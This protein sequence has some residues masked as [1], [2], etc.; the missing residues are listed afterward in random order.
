MV[1]FS[2]R[3]SPRAS[4]RIF[5]VKLPLATAVV[6]SAMERTCPVR[7]A[8]I[9][10][11]D[12]VRSF[13]VPDTPLTSA[14]PPSKP[15]VPTSRATRVTSSAKDDSWSTIV[16]RVDLSSRISPR[17]STSI[18]WLRSPRATAVAT[19][20]MFRT[21]PVR[22]PAIAFTD[23][24]RSFQV[25]DTPG[26]CAWPPSLPSVPTSRATRVTSEVNRSSWS[27]IPLK[28]VAISSIRG[29]PVLARRVLKSP[30]RTAVRPASNCSRPDSSSRGP[31]WTVS[32]TKRSHQL[33]RCAE[34][35]VRHGRAIY[36]DG[37]PEVTIMGRTHF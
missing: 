37:R 21:C 8:A 2:S 15:S 1:S 28:T 25:P 32:V 34:T 5:W 6:T 14:W 3:I 27:A 11:T 17:A 10:L 29:S 30:P 18:F 12:S 35:R 33:R 31:D 13:Q 7:L 36:T 20:A 24:V 16:L 19:W 9:T 23:S 26:T 4:T 22:L